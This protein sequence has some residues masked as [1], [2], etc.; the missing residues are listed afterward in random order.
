MGWDSG[1]LDLELGTAI[2][3]RSPWVRIPQQEREVLDTASPGP[4]PSDSLV[5]VIRKG[6][7]AQGHSVSKVFP[8]VPVRGA[9]QGIWI[10]PW[11]HFDQ[12]RYTFIFDAKIRVNL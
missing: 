12:E 7:M 2:R 5:C 4:T 8:N 1:T 11:D 9:T 10:L 6:I 3:W